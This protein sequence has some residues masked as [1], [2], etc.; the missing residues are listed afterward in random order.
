MDATKQA[1]PFLQV[2]EAM[3]V[4]ANRLAFAIRDRHHISPG[5]TLV[6]TR[7][8]FIDWWSATAAERTTLMALVDQVKSLLD[9]EFH[10]AGYNV[11]FNAGAAAGQTA[12]HLHVHVIPRYVG[13]TE[14]PCGANASWEVA[15]PR[16]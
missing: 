13:D 1:S 2:P 10:P 7:R 5:H 3:W 16:R 6:I 9:N 11:G 14:D 15:R 12:F 4:A 8:P